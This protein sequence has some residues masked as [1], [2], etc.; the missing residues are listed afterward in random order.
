LAI[1]IPPVELVNQLSPAKSAPQPKSQGIATRFRSIIAGSIGVMN[2][3]SQ[4][5]SAWFGAISTLVP[6]AIMLT[7]Y[8]LSPAPR[9]EPARSSAPADRRDR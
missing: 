3:A 9:E 7:I 5:L 8:N 6:I 4:F 1:D 2:H